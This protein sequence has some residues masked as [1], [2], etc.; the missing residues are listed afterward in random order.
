[1]D[2]YYCYKLLFFGSGPE[3][4]KLAILDRLYCGCTVPG[5]RIKLSKAVSVFGEICIVEF[6]GFVT[7][8]LQVGAWF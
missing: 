5:R 8:S 3:R 1:M 4:A 2:R 6:K 7:S